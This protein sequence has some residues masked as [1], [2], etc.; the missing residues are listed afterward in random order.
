M[1]FS[2]EIITFLAQYSLIKKTLILIICNNLPYVSWVMK[3]KNT[4]Q[5]IHRIFFHPTLSKTKMTLSLS[6]SFYQKTHIQL[7]ICW[8]W[9]IVY[10]ETAEVLY[11]KI[12][13]IYF[14]FYFDVV[15]KENSVLSCYFFHW[16][17]KFIQ[18]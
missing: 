1:S 17:M 11:S 12:H 10:R 3:K 4:M 6:L 9:S 18:S 2:D 8:M 14:F 15:E 16:K 5:I 7:I 13:I